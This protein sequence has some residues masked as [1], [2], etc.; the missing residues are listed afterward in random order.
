MKKK[1]GTRV[2]SHC[3]EKKLGEGG[4]GRMEEAGKGGEWGS[5]DGRVH[6]GSEQTKGKKKSDA[7]RDKEMFTLSTMFKHN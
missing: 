1:G 3:E 6:I 7:D 4:M 5:E 2:Q